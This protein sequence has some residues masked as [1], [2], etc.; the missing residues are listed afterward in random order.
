MA[1]NNTKAAITDL[2]TSISLNPN[3]F[4]YLTRGLFKD[5][6]KNY[7]GAILDFDHAIGLNPKF[8]EAYNSRGDSKHHIGNNAGACADW[9]KAVQLGNEQAIVSIKKYCK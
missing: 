9:K 1:V 8:G 7:A 3:P 2:N 4:A 6:I 5:I